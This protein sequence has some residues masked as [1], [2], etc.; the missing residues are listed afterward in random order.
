M[1]DLFKEL[2]NQ[3]TAS[4]WNFVHVILTDGA[5]NSSKMSIQDTMAVLNLIHD[6]LRNLNLRI[7]FIGVGV[8]AST[9]N[10]LKRLAQAAGNNG[11]YYD[12]D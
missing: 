10:S 1:L 9:A 3:R 12:I 6:T 11:V 4:G 2:A 5:D 8:D 7:I